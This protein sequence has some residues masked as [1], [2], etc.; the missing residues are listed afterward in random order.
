MASCTVRCCIPESLYSRS[1]ES[2]RDCGQVLGIGAIVQN[3]TF[4]QATTVTTYTTVAGTGADVIAVIV[5]GAVVAAIVANA[6]GGFENGDSVQFNDAS[7]GGTA[8]APLIVGPQ[9]GTYPGVV[10]YF[11][12]RRGYADSLNDPDS[13]FFSQPGAFTNL[14]QAD[15]P[16]LGS[17]AGAGLKPPTP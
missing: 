17:N 9:T 5:G 8:T 7:N 12:E 2:T 15:P 10:T 6:G 16:I 4:A 14:D 13:Y 3:G 11:Q 1:F